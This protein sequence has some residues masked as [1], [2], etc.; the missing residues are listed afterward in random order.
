M[1]YDKSDVEWHIGIQYMRLSTFCDYFRKR[2]AS[3]K[4]LGCI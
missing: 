2:E 3:F 4:F 1:K